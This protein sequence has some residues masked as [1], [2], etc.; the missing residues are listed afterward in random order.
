MI[1]TQNIQNLIDKKYIPG[2]AIGIR[3]GKTLIHRGNY[4]YANLE[5]RVPV[6]ENSVF[7]I[8][9]VTKLFT[10]QAILRLAQA[11]NLKL[12]DALSA[13]VENLP[14]AWKTITIQNCLTHQ[15][16]IPSYTSVDRYWELQRHDKTHAEVLDLVRD[17]PLNFAPG[18]R[19]A[20]D[21]TGFYLL[22]MVIEAVSKKIYGD[23]LREEIFAPLGMNQTQA[24][25][26]RR[27]VPDRAQG[28][29]YR[30]G[31][32]CNK[33]FY[34]VSNTFSAG[35]LLSTV[36]DLLMWSET[37]FDDRSLNADYR[38]LWWRP[39]PSE[40]GNERGRNY[41]VGLGWFMV[42]HEA[43]QFLG[44]NGGI[45]G[46]ASAFLYLPARDITA[47]ALCNA[48]HIEDPHE[49]ALDVIQSLPE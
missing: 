3:Q 33:D 37:L 32:M 17:L 16:G 12:D 44:H 21:N 39:H 40:V 27:I 14:E 5:H 25:D 11:G 30:D 7:E 20:Y 18:T 13:Y 31:V 41:S 29:V 49:I 28:Y 4:G 15:S 48:S 24:N 35:I 36:D 38:K 19:H 6:S 26:Y 1:D 42:D 23:Y 8:A 43:G 2:L 9:S 34:D 10:A 45:Q 47:V 22:G 46:F